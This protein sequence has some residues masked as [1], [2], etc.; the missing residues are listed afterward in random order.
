M[1]TVEIVETVQYL[2]YQQLI[3]HKWHL[4]QY[5][6]FVILSC[7]QSVYACGARLQSYSALYRVAQKSKPLSRIII[8]SY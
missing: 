4:L 8:K 3:I 5:S 7:N 1:E 6:D 2:S